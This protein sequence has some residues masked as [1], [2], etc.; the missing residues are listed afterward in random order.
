VVYSPS[1]EVI[2][3]NESFAQL[4]GY[5][6][7][8]MLG[9]NLRELNTQ[10]TKPLV[11]ERVMRLLAG[12]VLTFIADHYHRDGQV[13]HLEVCASK[14]YSGGK[15]LILAYLRDITERKAAEAKLRLMAEELE[16]RVKE[17]T[18]ELQTAKENFRTLAKAVEQSP[19]SVIITDPQGI[20][21]YVNPKFTQVMGYTPD[22]AIGQNPRMIKGGNLPDAF[23]N[24]MWTKI[25]SGEEWHG[26]FH[27][28]AK[29]GSLVWEVASISPIR[30]ESGNVTNFVGVKEDITELKHLQEELYYVASHDQLTGLSN[31]ML[32]NDRLQQALV[33]AKRRDSLF[34]L[35]YLDLDHFKPVNDAY[36]HKAGD[37]VLVEVG[38]RISGC[39][40]ESDT[41]ARM[42]G[43]EFTVILSDI[44]GPGA[45]EHIAAK[46][47][48]V[49]TAPFPVGENECSIGVSIGI[50]VYPQSGQTAD[51]LMVKAD[52]AMYQ[53][54][55][56]GRNG[57]LFASDHPED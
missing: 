20:I 57:Y 32:F 49:L 50:A 2:E 21:Q 51:E 26:I 10:E 23:Y 4:H 47:I 44:S 7:K 17:R 11:A 19:V 27:N 56:Q 37:A 15:P 41:V 52:T 24:T 35:M 45:A 55:K 14:I 42:G 43:D 48:R 16:Q 9:L 34:A 31:R 8:E 5:T 28:R 36:G 1:G 22:E 40:R 39:V 6:P 13:F 46:I 54:K 18:I 53:V 29:D 30:D 33:R 3:V 38:K 25:I 12:E